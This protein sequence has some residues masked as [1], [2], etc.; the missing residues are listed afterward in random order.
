MQIITLLSDWN[1]EDYYLAAV[2]GK[3]ASLCPDCKVVD[4]SHKVSPFNI[5]EAAY[6]LRNAYPFFPPGTIHIVSVLSEETE[7]A[8]HH[9]VH[10]GGQ[11]FIGADTG[12]FYM[13]FGEE[14]K[15]YEM[16]VPQD[17][18]YHTFPALDRFVKVAVM[19]AQGK[20]VQEAGVETATVKKKLWLTPIINEDSVTAHVQYIDSFENLILNIDRNTFEQARKGRKFTIHVRNQKIHQLSTRYSSV[21]YGELLALFNTFEYMEIAINQ[22]NA[23]KLLGINIKDAIRIEFESEEKERPG[24][25][26]TK[27]TSNFSAGGRTESLF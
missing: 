8:T 3:L 17:S 12:L 1:N 2:K 19:L 14:M 6:I 27:K 11:Y 9:I 25:N 10:A 13:V 7:N 26:K 20:P 16:D 15:V 4:I 24:L 22:G 21:P 23:S 5:Q 18:F